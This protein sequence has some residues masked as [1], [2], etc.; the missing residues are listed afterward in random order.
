[1]TTTREKQ[2]VTP[3]G[4]LINHALFEK[5]AYKDPS[6]GAESKPRYKA[7]M[8]FDPADVEDLE[9]AIVDAA[10]EEWGDKAEA[11]YDNGQI[12]S[13]IIDGDAIAKDR[14]S[15]GK[16]GDAYKGK[17]VVR[18]STQ[19]NKDGA[20]A[21]GGVFV[22]GMDGEEL[23]FTERNK[24]YNGCMGR[25]AV[26]PKAYSIP[27]RTGQ[28]PRRGITLYLTGFMLTGEGERLASGSPAAGA[29]KPLAKQGGAADSGGGRRRRKG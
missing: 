21:P 27:G 23:P 25:L 12:D 16:K 2:V 28:P 10:V 26:I 22:A 11:E 29:F 15:R 8:A 20:D 14:E 9:N 24:V 17:L 4:R 1:M 7:E 19:F 6:T 5:D 3:E 18:A 13:P